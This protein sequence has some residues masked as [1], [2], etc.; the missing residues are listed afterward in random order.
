MSILSNLLENLDNNEFTTTINEIGPKYLTSSVL[1]D[2]S[3][4][5]KRKENLFHNSKNMSSTLM[6]PKITDVGQDFLLNGQ[7]I[8]EIHLK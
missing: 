4:F 8:H 1:P 3:N 2:L 6:R 7:R 5:K